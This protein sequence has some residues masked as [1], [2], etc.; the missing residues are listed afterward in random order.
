[1]ASYGYDWTEFPAGETLCCEK[2][3]ARVEAEPAIVKTLESVT[4]DDGSETVSFAFDEDLEGGEVTALDSL[5]AGFECET[6][7]EMQARLIG[8]VDGITSGYLQD[9]YPSH[10]L[11]L[12]NA[13]LTDAVASGLTNRAAYI[14]TL[15][16]WAMSISTA[17]YA[18]KA[19]AIAATS[20][21]A[22][23]EAVSFSYADCA[24][25]LDGTDPAVTI[26]AALA[27]ED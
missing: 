6:L 25:Q 7:A 24:S 14:G 9:H 13:L 17:Y 12:W 3:T 18:S 15:L 8:E 21:K 1:M 10:D 27:I 20:T 16:A 22:E 2:L 19:Q 5:V 4:V 23:A 11:D 26:A